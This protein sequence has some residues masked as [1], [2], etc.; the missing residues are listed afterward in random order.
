MGLMGSKGK[1]GKTFIDESSDKKILEVDASMQGDFCFKD[2]VRLKINGKF[3]GTLD[4]KG[5]LIISKRAIVNAQ[6]KGEDIEIGGIVNG[7]I[8]ASRSLALRSSAIVTGNVTT[9]LFS[10]QIG[11]IFNGKCEMKRKEKKE[12]EDVDFIS[13]NLINLDELSDYIDID[14]KS[15]LELIEQEKIPARKVKNA[16]KFD[17]EEIDNWISS[18][19]KS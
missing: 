6:V 5:N 10:V 1:R 19:S 12:L 4:T 13:E 3:E 15:I 8:F 11:A 18:E 7:N 9:D 14:K 17:R 16:W 2:P